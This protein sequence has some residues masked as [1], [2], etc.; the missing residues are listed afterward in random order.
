MCTLLQERQKW[1]CCISAVDCDGGLARLIP[2]QEE[3]NLRGIPAQPE[4]AQHPPLRGRRVDEHPLHREWLL[5]VVEHQEETQKIEQHDHME[6]F[7]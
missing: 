3:L 6:G 7:R 4:E 1:T 5:G 2:L